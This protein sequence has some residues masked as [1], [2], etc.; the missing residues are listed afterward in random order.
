MDIRAF[1][2]QMYRKMLSD[3]LKAE[4]HHSHKNFMVVFMN[5]YEDTIVS[6]HQPMF[7]HVSV[8]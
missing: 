1:I 8:N 6:G 4:L 2:E 3:S 7:K 5:E